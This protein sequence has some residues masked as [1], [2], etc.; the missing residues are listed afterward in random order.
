MIGVLDFLT[1]FHEVEG[2]NTLRNFS[3]EDFER[4]LIRSPGGPGLLADVHAVGHLSM[5]QR[6]QAPC[7]EL[8]GARVVCASIMLTP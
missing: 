8:A 3:A 7:R 5:F 2:L 1:T 4:A 6:Q